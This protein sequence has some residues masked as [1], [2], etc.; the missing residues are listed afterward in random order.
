[1]NAVI[2]NAGPG[3]DR[4]AVCRRVRDAAVEEFRARGWTA[5]TFDAD[6]MMIKPCRGCFACWQR[7]PGTC[8]IKDDEEGYIKAFVASDAAVW[9]TP[10]TFGGYS[11]ALKKTL[12]RLIPIL[13]PFFT[14]TAGEIHHPQRYERRRKL[15]AVG[16]LGQPDAEAEGIF[17][18]LVH[19]NA[20]NMNSLK[21]DVSFVYESAPGAAI[22]ERVAE[23]IREA[24][25]S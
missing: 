12:D 18:R 9:I 16:T 1:M 14:K 11:S 2:L 3:N 23:L 17:S 13:L 5:Q 8:A 19:R 7:H 21:T 22:A 6:G 25:I 15:L 4:G 24:E 20:L 10:V